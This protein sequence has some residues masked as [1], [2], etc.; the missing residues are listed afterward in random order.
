MAINET[1]LRKLNILEKNMLFLKHE[2]QAIA[3]KVTQ[4]LPPSYQD[5]LNFFSTKI[6]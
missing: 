2:W 3:I 6:S 4:A 5:A 1:L